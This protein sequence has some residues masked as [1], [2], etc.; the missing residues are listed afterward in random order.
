MPTSRPTEPLHP[1]PQLALANAE[2][3][4]CLDL[5][6]ALLDDKPHAANPQ[7]LLSILR[8]THITRG[9]PTIIPTQ[10]LL[11]ARGDTSSCAR[12]TDNDGDALTEEGIRRRA[13]DRARA[14][15]W[16]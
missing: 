9:H 8:E 3:L 13:R 6:P 7:R 11:A 4:G 5:R 14:G 16:L 10:G 1:A 2:R 15:R 12:H